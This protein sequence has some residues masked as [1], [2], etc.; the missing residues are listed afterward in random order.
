M[1]V[2]R[3]EDGL[4]RL[5]ARGHSVAVRA[6]TRQDSA[7]AHDRGVLA[8]PTVAGRGDQAR[9]KYRVAAVRGKCGGDTAASRSGSAGAWSFSRNAVV[10]ACGNTASCGDAGGRCSDRSFQ[11]IRFKNYNEDE[12]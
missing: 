2:L 9:E 1:Q 5:Q 11:R 4:H 6:G 3:G 10:F 12:E 7:P 8:A